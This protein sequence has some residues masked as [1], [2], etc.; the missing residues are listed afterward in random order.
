MFALRLWS[1]LPLW[2][3]QGCGALAGWLAFLASPSYRRRLRDN[4]RLAGVRP[5][6]AVAQ[7]GCMLAELPW[8]WLRPAGR[9]LPLRWDGVERVEQALGAG[10]GLLL[11]TP[12]MGCFEAAAQAAAERFG[13]SAPITVLYR[14][15]RKDYLKALVAAGREREHLRAAPATL[16]GVRQMLR[17]LRAGE[18]VGLL[19]DQVPPDGL[20]VWAPFFGRPAYTMTLAARLLQQTGAP[21]LAVWCERL[22]WGRGFVLHVRA[23]QELPEPVEA[24]AAA[25][26]V[27]GAMEALIREAPAQ[28]LWGYNRYKAPPRAPAA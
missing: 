11:L 3:V 28:Y 23:F 12:H 1:R 21:A 17:A 16:S 19:P 24:E 10:R 4:A 15:A 20:G 25:T 27:N 7:A 9:P 6:G 13:A 8:M 22:A 5:W 26:R 18:I 2:F 14:P